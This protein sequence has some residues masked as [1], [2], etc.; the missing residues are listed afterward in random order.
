MYKRLLLGKCCSV[1]KHLLLVVT[2]S[3]TTLKM[4]DEEKPKSKK[5]FISAVDLFD[6]KHI[7]KVIIPINITHFISTF[8]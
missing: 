5:V 2:I 7:A 8:S 1:S 4:A 6:G 3:N